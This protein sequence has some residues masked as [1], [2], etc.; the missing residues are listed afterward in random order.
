M[1]AE[2]EGFQN[3]ERYFYDIIEAGNDVNEQNLQE[4]IA[5]QEV[6]RAEIVQET[7]E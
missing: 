5:G 4:A 6:T 7:E 2:I 1:I 3:A